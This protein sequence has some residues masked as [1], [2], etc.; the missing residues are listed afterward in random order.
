MTLSSARS[1]P[2]RGDCPHNGAVPESS[3]DTQYKACLGNVKVPLKQPH[4]GL[5]AITSFSV[6]ASARP[7]RPGRKNWPSRIAAER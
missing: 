2:L 1:S 7:S 5:I 4:F 3:P 6:V